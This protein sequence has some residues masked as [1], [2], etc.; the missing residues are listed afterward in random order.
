MARKQKLKVY[1]TPIGF[2]DAYVAAPS[3][4]AALKAWGSEA[5]LF[6]RGL[7]E[8]VNDETL[9]REPLENPGQVILR[10][11]GT[12]AEQLAA[13]PADR[14]KRK[15]GRRDTQD[16]DAPS[17]SRPIRTSALARPSPPVAKARHVEARPKPSRA[18]LDTAE[19][20][21]EDL[22]RQQDEQDRDLRRREQAL[23]RERRGLDRVHERDRKAAER[24][25]EHERDALSDA[26]ARWRAGR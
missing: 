2:H 11:R 17:R 18:K 14:P 23:A 8:E 21:L 5:N 13:L 3:Q 25:I 6:A 22:L 24:S 1:R 16:E 10:S 7:A 4:K 15:S 20:R 19:R 26:L 12:A 9:S